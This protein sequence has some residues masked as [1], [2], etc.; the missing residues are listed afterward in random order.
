MITGLKELV[1]FQ[2]SENG[3]SGRLPIQ[4]QFDLESIFVFKDFGHGL[5]ISIFCN[6]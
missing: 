3:F 6:R 1:A 5:G 4:Q 2:A